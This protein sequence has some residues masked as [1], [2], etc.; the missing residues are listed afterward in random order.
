MTV[1]SEAKSNYSMIAPR[2]VDLPPPPTPSPW[3]K[4]H[5]GPGQAQSRNHETKRQLTKLRREISSNKK[6]KNSKKTASFLCLANF[7]FYDELRM[8]TRFLVILLAKLL[9]KGLGG[10]GD[11]PGA[12]PK[13]L[14]QPACL[15]WTFWPHEWLFVVRRARIACM[16]TYMPVSLAAVILP[17]VCQ[18]RIDN[19]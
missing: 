19:L 5:P 11:A 9:A 18:S 3:W 6:L 15:V 16:S 1:R 14:W 4:R 8:T 12:A 13:Y 2:V 10:G 7:C 17:A